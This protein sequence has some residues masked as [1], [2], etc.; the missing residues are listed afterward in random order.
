MRR[1]KKTG[2]LEKGTLE[3]NG[4]QVPVKIYRERRYNV[5]ASIGKKAAILRLPIEMSASE[6]KDRLDWFHQWLSKT[7][8]RNENVAAHFDNKTYRDGDILVVGKRSYRLSIRHEDRRSHSGKLEKD[9]IILLKLSRHDEGE[10]LQRN[11]QHLLSRIVAQDFLPE[12]TR[13]VHRLNE[14]HFRRPIQAVRLKYNFSNWGSC[15]AKRNINL[16]TRLLFAPDEVIDYVII[17]EL[18]HLIELN[19]SPRFWRLVEKAMPDYEEKERWLKE[20]GGKLGF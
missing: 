16:S 7:L 2:S 9:N 5:R 11:V 13:R 20:H 12:I 4:Q 18:A 10:S 1:K 6:Q 14:Q 3:V 15:S 17:H 8:K 19:H